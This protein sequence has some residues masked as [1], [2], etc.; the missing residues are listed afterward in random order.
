VRFEGPVVNPQLLAILVGLFYVLVIGALSLLRREGLSAQIALEAL[1]VIAIVVVIGLATGSPV[2][3]IVL[4]ILLYL[5]TMRARL[6]TDL[7]NLFF[8]RWGYAAAEPLYRLALRLY[9]EHTSCLIVCINWGTARLK[10]GDV[11]GA[12]ATFKEVLA[13]VSERGGLGHKYEAACNFNLAV[14]YR[15][16]GDDVKA[17]L[18]FNKVIDLHPTS[19]Y[20]QAAEQALKKMRDRG[21][22]K[23]GS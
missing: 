18:Q 16:A 9:P 17:V 5:V 14:A 6:L 3:P 19:V 7:A 13:S 11:E 2:S 12:I 20:G 8:R 1:A 15:R 10:S 23:E 22:S 21:S 4:F